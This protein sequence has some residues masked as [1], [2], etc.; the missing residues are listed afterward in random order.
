[1][2]RAAA[3]EAQA[4]RSL[5]ERR[6][7]VEA[8]AAAHDLERLL[9]ERRRLEEA[10]KARAALAV[11]A[12]RLSGALAGAK[13][14]LQSGRTEEAQALLG[15]GARPRRGGRCLPR[16]ERARHAGLLAGRQPG[17]PAAGA[18]G[19]A[20]PVALRSCGHRPPGGCPARGRTAEPS[21]SGGPYRRSPAMENL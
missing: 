4:A 12:E 11:K 6:A 8:F 10:E 7:A 18:A 9:A 19:A 21:E 2:A 5:E 15:R 13:E 1:L 16:R 17:R 3:A 14:A 20:A